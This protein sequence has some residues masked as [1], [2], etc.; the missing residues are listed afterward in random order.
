MRR[1][2]RLLSVSRIPLALLLVPWLG[3]QARQPDPEPTAS[4]PAAPPAMTTGTVAAADGTP[5]AYEV[6]GEGTPALV[7]VHCWACNRGFWREQVEPFAADHR[8]VTLDLPGHGDSGRGRAEWTLEAYAEDVVRVVDALGLERLVLVGHSMGGPV[9][10]LAA[11]RL[12]GRATGV[13][14]VDTLHDADFQWPREAIE[15]WIASYDADYE[16]V[17]GGAIAA[18]VPSGGELQRWITTQAL[19]AD[20]AAMRALL[21]EFPRFDLGAALAAAQVP[22]RCV[23]AAPAGEMTFA[24]AIETNRRYGDFDA[25]LMEGVGHYPHLERPDEFNRHLR[26]LLPQVTGA[27]ESTAEESASGS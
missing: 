22:V 21:P 23:N 9:S 10:L 7:F 18:M 11:A 6:R 5:I 27:G 13:L 25:V 19:A 2:L 15:Q 17:M 1:L 20:R 8:V 14:C 16:A 3:C 12:P 26:E 24:T 4:Q